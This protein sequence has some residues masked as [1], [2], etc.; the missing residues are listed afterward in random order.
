FIFFASRAATSTSSRYTPSLHDALPIFAVCTDETC[1]DEIDILIYAEN[2]IFTVFIGDA[3]KLHGY[4]GNIDAFFIFK[5]TIVQYTAVDLTSVMLDILYFE[6][7]KAVIQRDAVLGIHI[8]DS[9]RI[10]DGKL[11]A[12]ARYLLHRDDDLLVFLK[13]HGSAFHTVRAYFRSFCI[14]QYRHCLTEFT[15]SFPD[16]SDA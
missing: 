7:D 5:D 4:T 16:I 1:C 3:R 12:V 6:F 9:S 2:D 13:F 14:K 15:G 8:I 11:F 10:S